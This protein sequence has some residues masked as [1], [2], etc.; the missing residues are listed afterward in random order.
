M[1]IINFYL[2]P[3]CLILETFKIMSIENSLTVF[4]FDNASAQDLFQYET[5]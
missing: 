1:I 2:Y 3:N 5:S 4:F